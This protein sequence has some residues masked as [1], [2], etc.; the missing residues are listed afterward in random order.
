MSETTQAWVLYAGT[1]TNGSGNGHSNTWAELKLEDFTFPSISE[2]EVL[3]EPVVGCWEG[4]MG[5]ALCRKPVDICLQRKEE[6]V[7]LG[8]AGVVRVLHCGSRAH[9]LIEGSYCLVFCNGVWDDHGY[10]KKIFAY[11]APHTVGLLAKRTKLHRKQLIPIPPRTRYSLEQWAA[12]SL[13]YITAWANWRIAYGC[14]KL[15]AEGNGSANK[16]VWAWGGGVAFAE[17]TLANAFGFKTTMISSDP[18]RLDL[19]QNSGVQAID[20]SK[21]PNLHFDPEE[22]QK[23]TKYRDAYMESEKLFL[24]EVNRITGNQGVSIF[25][26]FIGLPVY[27]A[28]LKALAR[29]G[30]ITS[31]GWKEGMNLP[32]VRALE[33]MNWHMHVNTHYARHDEGLDA[34]AFAE[35]HG[36]MPHLEGPPFEWENIRQLAAAY[37]QGTLSSYFPIF[38]V[39]AV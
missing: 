39:N 7:V 15:Q 19:I 12:F 4:N 26:D 22:Y 30:V 2:D 16:N 21:F 24:E 17:V 35:G 37:E 23:D 11:D 31:A 8:N 32:T 36:W 25:V 28:T 13:R 33:C 18:R 10:P 27:R 38:Q 9:D 29:P 3:V 5:H 20:R 1:R 14:W 6:K 34:V